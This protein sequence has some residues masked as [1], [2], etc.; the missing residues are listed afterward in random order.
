MSDATDL[1]VKYAVHGALRREPARLDR[2]ATAADR[3]P[4]RVLAAPAGQTLF[5]QAHRAHHG[6]ED[7]APEQ[8]LP[9]LKIRATSGNGGIS[10]RRL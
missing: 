2:V 3:D 1:A 5:E 8:R 10:A 4:V 6:A 9:V 7:G